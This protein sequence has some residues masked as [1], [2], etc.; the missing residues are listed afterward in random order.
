[1][2]D[3]MKNIYSM[4]FAIC[5]KLW[6]HRDEVILVFKFILKPGALSA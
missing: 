3:C 6:V 1:M 5:H 2:I 4:I